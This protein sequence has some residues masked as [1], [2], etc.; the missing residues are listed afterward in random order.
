LTLSF[1]QTN[2]QH[3]KRKDGTARRMTLKTPRAFDLFYV[4]ALVSWVCM[5]K[6]K[7]EATTLASLFFRKL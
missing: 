6:K 4:Q 5:T 2:A 1:G 7:R 3:G